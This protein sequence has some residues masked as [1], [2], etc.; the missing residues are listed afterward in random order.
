MHPPC[1][2]VLSGDVYTTL[3]FLIDMVDVS[4]ELVEEPHAGTHN[5]R[6]LARYVH[7]PPR[8]ALLSAQ[9]REKKA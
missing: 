7:T 5:K 8:V 4:L 3:S 6:S 9:G 2:T 1:Q